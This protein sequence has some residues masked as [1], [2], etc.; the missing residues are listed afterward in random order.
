MAHFSGAMFTECLIFAYQYTNISTYQ[1][2]HVS[3]EIALWWVLTYPFSRKEALGTL[4][5]FV[6][7]REELRNPIIYI[8]CQSCHFDMFRF[9]RT[10]K[11]QQNFASFQAAT[12]CSRPGSSYR[13]RVRSGPTTS[14]RSPTAETSATRP[15]IRKR[16]P[17]MGFDALS[18][19]SGE[20]RI[21]L[22]LFQYPREKVTALVKMP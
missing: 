10:A 16:P 1:R 19:V 8:I 9:E 3:T 2:C 14:R 15:P 6:N 21:E 12:P 18:T 11:T 4:L 13:R 5:T 20:M 22:Q 17:S 7:R